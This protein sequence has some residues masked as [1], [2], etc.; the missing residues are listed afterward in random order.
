MIAAIVF[1]ALA[2]PA[3]AFHSAG[4]ARTRG[5]VLEMKEM[6]KA[7]PFLE[8]PPKLDGSMIG[9]Y[10]FDPLGF[11]NTVPNTHY[12]QSAEI[13]HG[14]VAMLA[15]VG[16]ILQQYI[17]LPGEAYTESN[18][19]KAIATV[20]FVPNIQILLG[21]GCLELISWDKTFSG[22]SPAGDFGFD[23]MNMLKGKSEAEINTMK[24]KEL[25][26]GRLAMFA[27]I[28]LIWQNLAFDGA[29]SL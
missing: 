8:K 11:T 24:L 15:V 14:R 1:A 21:I 4:P 16:F 27:I 19:I 5:Q 28:G 25:K 6:S 23:P 13:K 26:N 22:S 18:P 9:D 17:H 7:L 12:V 3:L 20:G 29:P 10:G 2:A